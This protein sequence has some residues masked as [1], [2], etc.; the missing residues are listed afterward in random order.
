L[1]KIQIPAIVL[2]LL[3]IIGI[4]YFFTFRFKYKTKIKSFNF[5]VG[6]WKNEWIVD[7]TQGSEICTITADGKYYVDKEY[8]FNIE[9]LVIDASTGHISFIKASVRQS[10]DRNLRN[11]LRIVNNSKLEGIENDNKISYTKLS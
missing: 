9:N 4:I 1:Y 6:I 7:N 3:L 5:L 8:C 11:D 2:L 10:D